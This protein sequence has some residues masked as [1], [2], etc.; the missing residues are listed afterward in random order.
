MKTL[1]LLLALVAFTSCSTQFAADKRAEEHPQPSPTNTYVNSAN[2]IGNINTVEIPTEENQKR[3][4]ELS[5]Q[6]EKFLETPAE[7]K[8][9]DWENYKFGDFKLK[10]GKF[11]FFQDE[12]YSNGWVELG[13]V[14]YLDLSGDSK[15]E[16]IVEVYKT[17]CGASCNGGG[18]SVYFYK[19]VKGKAQLIDSLNAGS[20]AYGCA[21]KSLTIK[22]KK[23]YLE[24]FGTCKAET[25]VNEDKSYYCKYCVK[26]L[27]K[28]VYLID[29]NFKLVRD[30]VEIIETPLTKVNNYLSEVSIN[31]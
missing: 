15:K 29:A 7:F 13:Y 8:S 9:V 6:N 22:E 24:Q 21:I 14:Y 26:D 20:R 31:E 4:E 10:D 12:K 27:T 16:A 3:I 5:N 17:F 23:I 19:S 28:S 11:E 25:D 18:L 2:S 1:I 30:S